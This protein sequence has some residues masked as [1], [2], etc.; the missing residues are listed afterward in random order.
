MISQLIPIVDKLFLI[1]NYSVEITL[2]NFS[3]NYFTSGLNTSRVTAIVSATFQVTIYFI[4]IGRRKK[5]S[6]K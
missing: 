5:Y 1:P 4:S 6:V 2:M 3:S